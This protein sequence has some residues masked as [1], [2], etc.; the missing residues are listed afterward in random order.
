MVYTLHLNLI[1]CKKVWF[2]NENYSLMQVIRNKL[3]RLHTDI[4]HKTKYSN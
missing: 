3:I 4:Y 2:I 1:S